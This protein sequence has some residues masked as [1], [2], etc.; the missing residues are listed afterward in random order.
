ML[1]GL[2]LYRYTEIFTT[3]HPSEP[4]RTDYQVYCVGSDEALVKVVRCS[5]RTRD[6]QRANP[7]GFH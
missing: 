1:S 5:F 2:A 3:T 6:R 4:A 7:L